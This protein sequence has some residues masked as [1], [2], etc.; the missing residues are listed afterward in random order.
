METKSLT[1][2]HKECSTDV[3]ICWLP[4]LFICVCFRKCS[5][6]SGIMAME[7]EGKAPLVLP[8]RTHSSK[9]EEQADGRGQRK[10]VV[11][12]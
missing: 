11:H 1:D 7:A 2:S 4:Q 9:S 10:G 12:T 8:Q 3:C 6:D 5:W